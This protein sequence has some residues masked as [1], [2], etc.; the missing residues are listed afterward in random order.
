MEVHICF[1][2]SFN[3]SATLHLKR[4]HLSLL[5]LLF[6]KK[7]G[8]AFDDDWNKISK[9]IFGKKSMWYIYAGLSEP[10]LFYKNTIRPLFT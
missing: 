5:F 10:L 9:Q 4:Y 6:S 3:E 1:S 8:K 2:F 7:N